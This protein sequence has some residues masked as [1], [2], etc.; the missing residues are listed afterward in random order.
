MLHR[1]SGDRHADTATEAGGDPATEALRDQAK[2]KTQLRL[3]QEFVANPSFIDLSLPPLD[4][5]ASAA[6]VE[7]R[8]RNLAYKAEL[9]EALGKVLS[10]QLTMLLRVKD[11]QAGTDPDQG[12]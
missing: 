1:Q 7:A 6:D 3:I 10:D 2:R 4:V 5:S 8:R 9:L 12:G 11:G